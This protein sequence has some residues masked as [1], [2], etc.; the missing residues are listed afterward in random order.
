MTT[1]SNKDLVGQFWRELRSRDDLHLVDE[2]Y[3]PG[4][5]YHGAGGEELKGPEELRDYVAGYFDAFPDMTI[6][7]RTIFAEGEWVASRW[8]A[9]GTHQGKL[10]GIP[11]TGKRIAISGATIQRFRDGKVVEEWEYPDM[12]SLLGQLGV[13]EG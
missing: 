5:V 6:E 11:P 4:A 10:Q 13:L 9:T 7:A 3:A 12:T 8:E 2:L 1:A